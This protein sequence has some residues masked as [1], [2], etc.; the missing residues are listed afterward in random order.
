[1]SR[2]APYRLGFACLVASTV[3]CAADGTASAVILPWGDTLVGAAQAITSVL[4]P[5]AI[6]AATAAVARAAGPLRFLVTNTLVERLVRNVG[7]YALNAVSG[8]VK[9]RTLTVAVGSVVIARA[10][11][12]A[13]DQAPAWLIEAAGG[14]E[15]LAAKVF[16]SLRLEEAAHADNTLAPA[17]DVL[18][19]GP[20]RTT[21]GSMR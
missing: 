3:P 14:P 5:V 6:A 11:Q 9:G 7:D 19:S 15:G 8:A 2:S 10:V 21:A 16:R 18:R 13:L 12:R 17:L 1:M 20:A 4:L